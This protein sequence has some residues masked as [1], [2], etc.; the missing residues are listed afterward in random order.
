MVLAEEISY[1]GYVTE[2][3]KKFVPD[4]EKSVYDKCVR[5]DTIRKEL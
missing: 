1:S 2:V 3:M 5:L 4:D